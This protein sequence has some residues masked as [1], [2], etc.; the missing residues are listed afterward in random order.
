MCFKNDAWVVIYDNEEPKEFGFGMALEKLKKGLKVSRKGWNGKNMYV[1]YEQSRLVF[2]G[3][4]LN[5]DIYNLESDYETYDGY[6]VI[7][8]AET[9]F[10]VW[11]PSVMDLLAEDWYEVVC[12]DI[13]NSTAK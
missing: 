4:K 3:S 12:Q 1:Y 9:S 2:G 11:T 5:N 7:R 6:F 8:Y 13:N 10:A